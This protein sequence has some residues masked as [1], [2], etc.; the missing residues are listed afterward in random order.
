MLPRGFQ[1]R[2]FQEARVQGHREIYK[3]ADMQ[4]GIC[5]EMCRLDSVGRSS[6]RDEVKD[7]KAELKY[8]SKHFQLYLS[9]LIKFQP[10]LCLYSY[11][12]ATLPQILYKNVFW[13]Y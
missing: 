3:Q 11:K 4:E 7:V 5:Q 6:V 2:S 13:G 1:E 8:R 9:K 12:D 10:C